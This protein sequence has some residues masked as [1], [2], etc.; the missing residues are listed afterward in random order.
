[1]VTLPGVPPAAALCPS[2][3]PEE[4]L[5]GLRNYPWLYSLF[6]MTSLGLI[7][8]LAG[9]LTAVHLAVRPCLLPSLTDVSVF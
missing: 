2:V 9:H 5:L 1:M 8:F 7:L 3:S 6:S 4:V